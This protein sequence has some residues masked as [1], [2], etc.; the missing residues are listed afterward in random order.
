MTRDFWHKPTAIWGLLML[1]TLAGFGTA[2]AGGAAFLIVML[3]AWLKAR[4]IVRHFME[5]REAPREWQWAFDG[6]VAAATIIIVG[7]HFLA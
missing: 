1:A 7:L 4:L 2:Q 3:A 6:L 5:L